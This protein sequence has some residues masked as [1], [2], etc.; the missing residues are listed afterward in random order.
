MACDNAIHGFR[1]TVDTGTWDR[2]VDMKMSAILTV[3]AFSAALAA[4]VSAQEQFPNF[5]TMD[6]N[7]DGVVTKA[8]FMAALT[9]AQKRLGERVF[10]ARDT[11]KDG[12]LTREEF[13][14]PRR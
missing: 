4:P 12:K 7:R 10:D 3:A 6:A 11:D 2:S 9:D 8:E 13:N 5:E 14:P 1:V